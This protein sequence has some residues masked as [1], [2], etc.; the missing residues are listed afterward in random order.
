ML[1]SINSQQYQFT[2]NENADKRHAYLRKQVESLLQMS[3]IE[4]LDIGACER[5]SR[6]HLART[7]LARRWWADIDAKNRAAAQHKDEVPDDTSYTT[8]MDWSLS[9]LDDTVSYTS[10][11]TESGYESDCDS[12]DDDEW[13]QDIPNS[14][15]PVQPYVSLTQ[16]V[17]KMSDL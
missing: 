6:S 15:Q 9:D 5:S 11:Y 13:C 12:E 3:E 10:D 17:S 4:L 8:N 7:I 1:L 14:T 16:V 2:E